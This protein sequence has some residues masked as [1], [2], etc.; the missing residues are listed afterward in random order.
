[1]QRKYV[2]TAASLLALGQIVSPA[3]SQDSDPE[4][5]HADEWLLVESRNIVELF[6]AT[7]QS[8]LQ[9][10]MASGGPVAA[11]DVCKH[12]A[13]EIAARISADTGAQVGR[14]SSRPRNPENQPQSWQR[15]VLETFENGSREEFFERTGNK[16]ARYMRAIKAGAIC[17][18]CHGTALAPAIR[19]KLDEAYPD[20]QARGYYLDDL[21]GAFS[22]VWPDRGP[23]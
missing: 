21:R 1:M 9:D 8:A 3:A 23:R 11:I 19:A 15:D 18:N 12:V 6:G 16:G 2:I 7:L 4:S 17:L 13:P 10:A 14:T 5:S 20:D 22:V